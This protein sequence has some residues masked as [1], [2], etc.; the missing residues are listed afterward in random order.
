MT[1]QEKVWD[2]IA[3]EWHE[4]KK[5]PAQHVKKFLDE[6]SGKILDLGSGSGRNMQK[7]KNG[8]MHLVDFSK[9]MLDLAEKKAKEEGI[10]IETKK[11]NLWEIDYPE[12][13]FD[14]AIC[15]SAIHCVKGEENRINALKELYRVLKQNGRVL[16]GVW[17]VK[18]KRF[19][20][21][22]KEK[23][24]G[25]TNKG[26]RYYYLYD[27]DEIH[28]QCK[29]VGFKIIETHNSEVMINFICQKIQ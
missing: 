19:R 13:Y 5:M 20:N 15:I 11:S 25:W 12:N 29:K 18:S 8:K 16:I 21:K 4:Y 28:S 24:I 9:K 23:M 1:N 27:E 2:D 14:G 6:S 17:N 10:E 7:I 22:N 26:E 3:P